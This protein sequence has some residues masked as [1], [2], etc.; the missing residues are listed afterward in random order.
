MTTIETSELHETPGGKSGFYRQLQAA[1]QCARQ[2][3]AELKH[4]RKK[5]MFASG[6]IHGL[7]LLAKHASRR[8]LPVSEKEVDYWKETF[9][10]WFNAVKR[11]FQESIREEFRKKA[12]LDF[13]AIREKA[14]TF[15]ETPWEQLK[16]VYERPVRFRNR[17]SFD[18]ACERAKERFPIDLGIALD[19]YLQACVQRL[20]TEDDP[21]QPLVVKVREKPPEDKPG[22][23]APRLV[24]FDDGTYSLIVTSFRGLQ[25]PASS[26]LGLQKAV[27]QF[28]QQNSKQTLAGLEFDS[29]SSMFCV[30]SGSLKSLATV[31]EAIYTIASNAR[32]SS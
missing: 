25:R 12:E 3:I 26:G 5:D 1:T 16:D 30:R 24:T 21:S 9:F 4:S 2:H 22:T 31:S 13:E 18:L 11:Y 23:V 19:K 28:L 27:Q 17:E 7:A 32:I 15:S 10:D 8:S 14:G 6:A 29:E 20:L